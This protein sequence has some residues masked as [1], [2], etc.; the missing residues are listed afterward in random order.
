MKVEAIKNF[1]IGKNYNFGAREKSHEGV[2]TE[3]R[4]PSS[5]LTKVPVIVMLAMN[6]A[7]LNSAIPMIPEND[8]PNR[9]IMLAPETNAAEKSSY[10]ISPE[11]QQSNT[12]P[13]GWACFKFGKVQYSAKALIDMHQNMDIVYYN[14]SHGNNEVKGIYLVDPDR[15]GS[16]NLSAHPPEINKIIYHDIGKENEYCSVM[17]RGD[18][19]NSEGHLA[20]STYRE[21]RIDDDT[22]NKL[23]AF[24]LNKTEFENATNIE[25]VTT[26]RREL[27]K[28]YVI[29]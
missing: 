19:L 28:P 5:M 2:R 11:M 29:R 15:K 8:N 13:F 3:G 12:P 7:T 20:G 21:M 9:I 18:L 25:F 16:N 27:Y 17:T 6:P 22:A 1:S 10:V 23:L 4:A 26:T 24:L 14:P